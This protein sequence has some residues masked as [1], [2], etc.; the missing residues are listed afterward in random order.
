MKKRIVLMLLLSALGLGITGCGQDK[1]LDTF[2][3]QISDFCES[4]SQLDTDIN[5]IDATDDN[6]STELLGY[7]DTMDQEFKELA[8]ISFPEEFDY[9]EG[10]SDEASEYMTEAASSYHKLYEEDAYSKQLEE[11][12]LENY[13]RA[14]KRV[15]IMLTYLQGKEP[16]DASI[17][18]DSQS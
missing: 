9:L 1:E 7:L 15:Q 13:K 4:I 10:L 12:A 6:A 8:D 14:Y 3:T 5:N 2:K 18:T 16:D 17:V 11:Y